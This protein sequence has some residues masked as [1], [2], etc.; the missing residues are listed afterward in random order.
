[1]AELP[2]PPRLAHMVLRARRHR[3]GAIACDLAAV[4][5]E[6]DFVKFPA[7]EYDADLRLRLEIMAHVAAAKRVKTGRFTID[8]SACRRCLR[9]TDALRQRLGIAKHEPSLRY[10]GRILAWG[11]PDRVGQRRPGDP[12]RFLLTTG[13]GA[14]FA[15]PDALATADYIVAANL[16]GERREA[17]IFLARMT[18]RRSSRISAIVNRPET[19]AWTGKQVARGESGWRSDPEVE[20]IA[21]AFK[22]FGGSGARHPGGADGLP[23]MDA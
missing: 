19:I 1:M 13:R 3:L 7:G 9:L 22:D 16:D 6:R 10:I 12:G 18:C 14:F 20:P 23:A 17:R 21:E 2:L 11:Y 15:S 5:S 8:R 4:L